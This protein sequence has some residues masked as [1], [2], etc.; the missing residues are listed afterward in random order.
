M[1]SWMNVHPW[2]IY[3]CLRRSWNAS[4]TI[5]K[6][7]R[8]RKTISLRNLH[9]TEEISAKNSNIA[10][11]V[12]LVTDF[13]TSTATILW[14]RQFNKSEL[15]WLT[16][17]ALASKQM[18]LERPHCISWHC[19]KPVAEL[20]Q[21]LLPGFHVDRTKDSFCIDWVSVSFQ[22]SVGERKACDS[23]A[24]AAP[25]GTKDCHCWCL[26]VGNKICCCRKNELYALQT[27]NLQQ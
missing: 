26:I 12:F 16:I 1:S 24:G 23:M 5:Q 15:F 13:A 25:F 19:S 20:I 8:F 18:L 3:V 27:R 21:E 14:K 6:T 22:E 11:M 9:K 4:P 2:W 10:S 17:Q 7:N